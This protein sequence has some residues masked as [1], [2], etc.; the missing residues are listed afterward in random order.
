MNGTIRT[1]AVSEELVFKTKIDDNEKMKIFYKTHYQVY[2][3][4]PNF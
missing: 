2:C 4:R 3:P 1:F